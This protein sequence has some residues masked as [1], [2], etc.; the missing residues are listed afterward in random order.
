MKKKLIFFIVILI[1][2]IFYALQDK[3]ILPTTNTQSI[4]DVQVSSIEQDKTIKNNPKNDEALPTKP[5]DEDIK[6]IKSHV[7]E[8]LKD[9]EYFDIVVDFE[10][11]NEEIMKRFAPTQ[12]YQNSKSVIRDLADCLKDFCSMKPD[13]DGFFDPKNTVADKVLAKNLELLLLVAR[14]GNLFEFNVNDLDFEKIFNSQNLKVQKNALEL[15]LSYNNSPNDISKLFDYADSFKDEAK[16]VFYAS[17]DDATK[18]NPDLRSTYLSA[19]STD[20]NSAGGLEKVEIIKNLK[21]YNL[22]IEELPSALSPLCQEESSKINDII[23]VTLK[24]LNISRSSIC[25]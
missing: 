9:S 16:G 15:Y 1:I 10:I 6:N 14:E 8:E 4:P 3:K 25:K 5:K 20:L 17:L 2:S 18:Q 21:N 7:R 24:D 19:I 13:E 23:N 22:D 11:D 12:I